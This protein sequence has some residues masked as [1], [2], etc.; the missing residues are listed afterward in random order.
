MNAADGRIGYGDAS[1]DWKVQ[2]SSPGID[3]TASPYVEYLLTPESGRTV[4]VRSLVLHSTRLGSSSALSLAFFRSSDGFATQNLRRTATHVNLC[5]RIAVD[6]GGVT[7][8]GGTTL[9]V[10]MYFYRTAGRNDVYVRD[11]NESGVN[12]TPRAGLTTADASR[13]G[14]RK[15]SER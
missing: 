7:V 4:A 9:A 8:A 10:R 6:L 12:P 5:R 3:H 13:A 15:S 1:R 2:N 11:R 14:F